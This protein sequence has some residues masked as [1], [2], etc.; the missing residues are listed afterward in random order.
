MIETSYTSCFFIP[1]YLLLFSDILSNFSLYVDNNFLFYLLF[2]YENV[3][4][5]PGFFST[6]IRFITCIQN[7]R[8]FFY[9]VNHI[10]PHIFLWIMWIIQCIT[11]FYMGFSVFCLWITFVYNWWRMGKNPTALDGICALFTILHNI[12]NFIQFR[13]LE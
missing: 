6:K 12:N 10:I 4:S 9:S 7:V 3:N 1:F 11:L 8:S 5:F 2:E 13:Y